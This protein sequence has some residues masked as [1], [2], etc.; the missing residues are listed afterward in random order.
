MEFP[1]SVIQTKKSVST[2]PVLSFKNDKGIIAD[3][4][5]IGADLNKHFTNFF[6]AGKIKRGFQQVHK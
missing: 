3:Q 5:E 1:E 4:S 6:T 2:E